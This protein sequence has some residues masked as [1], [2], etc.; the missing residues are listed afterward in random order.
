[1][2]YEGGYS[3]DSLDPGGETKFGISKRAYP[4][5]NIKELTLE[6]AKTIY[7][8][9]YWDRISC[10][11]LHPAIRLIVFDCAVNQG[12]ARASIYL[13][14]SVGVNSD[15]MLGPI[16]FAALKDVDPQLIITKY[17]GYRHES[18]I[19]NPRWN[20]FGAGWSARLLDVTIRSLIYSNA[21]SLARIP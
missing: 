14:R 9:D 16:T 11:L 15:G 6:N 10:D 17:A 7:R 1:M 18:Y 12:V 13:Q 8:L 4:K 19:K 2:R 20:I 21:L 3:N 5:L